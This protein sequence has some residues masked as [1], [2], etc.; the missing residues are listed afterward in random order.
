MTKCDGDITIFLNPCSL[1]LSQKLLIM[2]LIILLEKNLTHVVPVILLKH[3]AFIK[4]T[5]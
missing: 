2:Q 4:T 3:I 5:Q 1:F